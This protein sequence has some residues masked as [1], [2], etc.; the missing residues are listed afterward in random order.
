MAIEK[1]VVYIPT[2]H[3]S[4]NPANPPA[5]MEPSNI[6]SLVKSMRTD[7]LQYPLLVSRVG[8]EQYQIIDGHR[9]Y[10]V[11]E[12]DKHETIPCIV[13]DGNAA[14]LFAT[15]NA[16]SK[17]L[18]PKDW[19]IVFVTGGQIPPGQTANNLQ[20]LSQ[21]IG[22]EGIRR[23]TECG[24]SPNTYQVARRVSK[25]IG[26]QQENEELTRIVQWLI[27]HRQ[28]SNC[29]G[30]M[31]SQQPPTLIQDALNENRPVKIA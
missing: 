6:K 31:T 13:A 17:P 14:H 26:M 9:R 4:P 8:E 28:T 25:Y 19:A 10:A 23:M 1:V 15:V 22:N 7:G 11:L 3:L 16:N 20:K 21:L 2:S 30:V 12:A 18:T 5:R 27:D 29:I 24:L